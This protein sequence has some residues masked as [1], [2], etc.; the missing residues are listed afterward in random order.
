MSRNTFGEPVFGWCALAYAQTRWNRGKRETLKD[1]QHLMPKESAEKQAPS[2]LNLDFDEL[3]VAGVGLFSEEE[4]VEIKSGIRPAVNEESLDKLIQCL[5]GNLGYATTQHST[6]NSP[7]MVVAEELLMQEILRE[8]HLNP[9]QGTDRSNYISRLIETYEL[10][11]C[12]V[13]KETI[14]TS[15]SDIFRMLE[16]FSQLGTILK[17]RTP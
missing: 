2:G 17:P 13:A 16:E 15:L 9:A 14:V 10:E 11:R 12:D 8:F 1:L 7:A 3:I 6:K 5:A 4:I